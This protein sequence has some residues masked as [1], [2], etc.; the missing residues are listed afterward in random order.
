MSSAVVHIRRKAFEARFEKIAS[1]ERRRRRSR[2]LSFT[3][4]RL[5]FPLPIS[6]QGSITK[7]AEIHHTVPQGPGPFRRLSLSRPR[8]RSSM[9]IQE[10]KPLSDDSQILSQKDQVRPTL[11]TNPSFEVRSHVNDNDEVGH[12][13]FSTNTKSAPQ[14]PQPRDQLS[15]QPN[16]ANRDRSRKRSELN[17]KSGPSK[18][19]KVAL[20][21]SFRISRNSAF[22]DLTEAQREELGGVEYRALT[23]LSIIVPIYFVFWQLLGCL[24]VGAYIAR[25]KASVTRENGINPWY[26]FNEDI[27]LVFKLIRPYSSGG[28]DHFLR[29][30]L[31]TTQE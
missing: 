8:S 29:F 19:T 22:H 9:V 26:A 10:Q 18:N 11:T 16:E 13:A 6:R 15:T 21:A 3:N 14:E 24:V 27:G 20:Y 25:N 28:R 1:E 31:S 12:V 2:S 7:D 17:E 5:P 30:P 4:G 23:F